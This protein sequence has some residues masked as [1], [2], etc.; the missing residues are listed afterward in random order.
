MDVLADILDHTG[1]RSTLGAR[2]A[3]GSDWGSWVEPA[4][5]N[6]ALHAVTSGTAWFAHAGEPAPRQ[7]L[8]GDVV[9]LPTGHAHALG[10]DPDGVARAIADRVTDYEQ[11]AD[12]VVRIGSGPVRSHILCAHYTCDPVVTTSVLE[13]LPDVVHVH[14]GADGALSDTVRLLAR[15]LAEPGPA[16]ELMLNRLVDILLVQ[17]LRAWVAGVPADD[18]LPSW[19]RGMRDP[20]VGRAVALLHAEPARP[21]TTA[22]LADAIAVSRTTLSRRFP[23]AVG[24]TP[25]AYLTRWRM[26][27]AARRLAHT[28]EPLEAIAES[29]GYSSVH[30][31]NRAFR[32]ARGAPP[33]RFRAA[34]RAAA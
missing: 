14:G 7:L 6:A 23:A 2:I 5:P 3:A 12:G 10:A 32:R 20:L 30:A 9:L 18:A 19:L 22:T 28:D 16:T 8:P 34:S 13:L 24:E 31:F 25:G 17:L 21:W 26:D 27:L 15:E 33:G 11:T 29:V 1:V 4:A